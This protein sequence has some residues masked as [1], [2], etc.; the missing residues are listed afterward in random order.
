NWKLE[1]TDCT[2]YTEGPVKTHEPLRCMTPA[3]KALGPR[4]TFESLSPTPTASS[5]RTE[6]SH[7]CP[8]GS[9]GNPQD[10]HEERE[11][12]L[13]DYFLASLIPILNRCGAFRR[14][15]GCPHHKDCNF[16]KCAHRE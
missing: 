16:R 6:G 10:H 1:T 12:R 5:R 9:G 7:S 2:E 4:R 11:E 8:R 14:Q 3:E 13:G 15:A